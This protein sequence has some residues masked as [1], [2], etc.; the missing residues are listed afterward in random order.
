MGTPEYT[1][2]DW[3]VHRS[4]GVG[5][6]K[7]VETKPIQGE[8]TECF[9]IQTQN[10][11]YWLPLHNLDTARV[12]PVATQ[13]RMDQAIRE[14]R[15]AKQEIDIDRLYWKERIE[16]VKEDGDVVANSRVVRDL[17]LLRS[18]RRLNQT[19][20]GALNILTER[21]LREWSAISNQDIDKIRPT[22][23]DTLMKTKN[24]FT[25]QSS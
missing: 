8:K 6:I 16:T 22:L 11:T 12:R 19:E 1:I 17:T 21:L 23:T 10:G 3:I 24:K 25:A 4:Y 9:M 5:Q 20:E 15:N 14:L 2:N 18:L 13:T 7:K